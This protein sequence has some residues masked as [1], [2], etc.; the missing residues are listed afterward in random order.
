MN[1]H[2]DKAESKGDESLHRKPIGIRL[3]SHSVR[4]TKPA[5]GSTQNLYGKRTYHPPPSGLI[6]PVVMGC[7][8]NSGSGSGEMIGSG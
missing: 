2:T 5:K 1:P 3:R 8:V 7:A 4:I 6:I